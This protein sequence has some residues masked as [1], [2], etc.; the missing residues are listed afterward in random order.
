MLHSPIS[1]LNDTTALSPQVRKAIRQPALL[2]S[3]VI[4]LM[5]AACSDGTNSSP[6]TTSLT[7]TTDTDENTVP[8]AITGTNGKFVSEEG[9]STVQGA[10]GVTSDQAGNETPVPDDISYYND[11]AG[12]TVSLK[13]GTAT[14]GWGGTDTLTDIENVGGSAY[15]DTIEGSDDA[16]IIHGYEGN[17]T[18]KG[19][20]GIDFLYGGTGD[21]DLFGD[22]GDD[23]LFGDEGEDWLYGG[24]GEDILEGD[25]DDDRLY[26]D[27]DDDRLYGGEGND[28]LYGG[29][30]D[31][32]IHAEG[33]VNTVT[34]GEGEDYF[35]LNTY[36]GE[37]S[38]ITVTDF[39]LN[40]DKIALNIVSD[41]DADY[42]DI[43]DEAYKWD[44]LDEIE[45]GAGVTFTEINDNVHIISSEPGYD[46]AL[47]LEGIELDDLQTSDFEFV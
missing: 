28:K 22:D 15:D 23:E 29:E 17:D 39:T 9:N 41:F 44:S 3:P 18:I 13:E 2:S 1:F 11:P 12:V 16:N 25:E 8:T 31:D 6:R 20:G 46:F 42:D 30:G 27:D 32:D 33:G 36:K 40:E 10:N 47:I 38:R 45:D 24:S 14:D 4:L 43:L 37:F 34:G 21:D 5:L 26:G 35:V 19:A 7:D